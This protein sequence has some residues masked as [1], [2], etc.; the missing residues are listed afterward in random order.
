LVAASDDVLDILGI[1][2]A[3]AKNQEFVEF[4]SGNKILPGSEPAAHCY[5]GM[6]L[7]YLT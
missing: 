6:C 5:C 2:P 1:D 7:N 3:E 4:L